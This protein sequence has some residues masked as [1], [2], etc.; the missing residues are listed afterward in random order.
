MWDVGALT[1]ADSA[2]AAGRVIST[3]VRGAGALS[4]TGCAAKA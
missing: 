2:A 4:D 3:G 1:E